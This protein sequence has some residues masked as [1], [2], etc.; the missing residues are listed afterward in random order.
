[1]L[2]TRVCNEKSEHTV[3][4]HPLSIMSNH[5][6]VAKSFKGKAIEKGVA[7]PT[8]VSVNRW[9]VSVHE[10]CADVCEINQR[11]GLKQTVSLVALQFFQV[12]S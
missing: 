5:R 12:P 2:S 1:M 4:Q 11:R 6:E 10:V 3:S 9:V 7:F 8:C